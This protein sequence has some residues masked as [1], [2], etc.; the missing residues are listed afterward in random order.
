MKSIGNK[1]F[2]NC[3]SVETLALGNG[4]EEIA[5]K[6]FENCIM[7]NMLRLPRNLQAIYGQAFAGCT[8]LTTVKYS[9]QETKF[10]KY[11][12]GA[13]VPVERNEDFDELQDFIKVGNSTEALYGLYG[14]QFGVNIVNEGDE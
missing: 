7:L 1:A 2:A 11:L 6:A 10:F 3:Y 5:T 9:T 8:N 13:F 4:L 12:N 14:N